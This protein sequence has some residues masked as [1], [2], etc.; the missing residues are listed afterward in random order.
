MSMNL[1]EIQSDLA[2]TKKALREDGTY[3]G[4]SGKEL[5]QYFLQLN[6]K[7]NLILSKQLQSINGG[8][9]LGASA[10]AANGYSNKGVP[11][12]SAD[13]K[14]LVA[15]ALPAGD[16]EAFD[17]D[18]LSAVCA[19]M[20]RYEASPT[21]SAKAL[22][23]LASLAYANASQVGDHPEVLP[24]ALR[25]LDLHTTEGNVQ[26]N[27]MRALCNMAYDTSV[28]LGKLSSQEVLGAFVN[29]M[30][31]TSS[32][33]GNSLKEVGARASEAVARVVAAEV[34]PDAGATPPA[35]KVSPERGPLRALF[36]VA[37]PDEAD[38]AAREVVGQLVEQLISN[39]VATPEFLAKRLV[40]AATPASG[41]GPAAA[42]WLALAKTL[43]MKEISTMSECLINCR[44]IPAAHSVMSAQEEYG[45][46]QLAGIEAMS[47][48]VGSRWP[49]LQAFA[50]VKGIERIEV[51]MRK[52]PDESV[53]QTKGIRALASGIQ[54]P[55]D[56]QKKA[57]YNYKNGVELTKSAMTNHGEI[58]ELQI[59][60]LEALAKY[61]DRKK[62]SIEIVKNEGGVGLV[63]TIMLRYQNAPKVKGLGKT[64]LEALGEGDWQP[65]GAS[66]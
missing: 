36:T 8:D 26:I 52:H 39:E 17:R 40:E 6:Q 10:P 28:A 16:P 35:S 66:A 23:A 4:M 41:N 63:K 1:E 2:L 30:A 60:G 53:L 31:R 32:D 33:K 44:A 43:A 15:R 62:D 27:G 12:A 45:P 38:K 46:A 20:A 18:N 5:Q 9:L 50:D 34:G 14:D 48:L 19:H 57:G 65:K 54:W 24:Q 13:K 47:G 7:E 59:A 49:G 61:L 37:G 56:I 25:L 64:I 51:A 58:E 11:L 42:A 55:D 3:L 22:R 21:E 29:A